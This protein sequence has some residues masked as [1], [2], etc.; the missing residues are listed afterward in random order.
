M[1]TLFYTVG[2]PASGKS[3][4]ARKMVEEANGTLVAIS[5]DELRARP[6]APSGRKRERWVVEQQSAFIREHLAAGTSVIVH[7][8]NFNPVHPARF[9]ALADE[10]G[11][12]LHKLDLTH[13]DVHECIRRDAARADHVGESVI[14]GMWQKYCYTPPVSHPDPALAA[15]VLVDIDGTLARMTGRSPYHWDRVHEDEPVGHVVELVRDLAG[16]GTQ[17]VFLS[18]RD[19]SCRDATQAWIDKHVGVDGLL[20]MRAA[21]DNRADSIVKAELFDAHVH[22]RFRVRFVLDDRNSVVFMWRSKGIP[23]LQVEYGYF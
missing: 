17:I 22:G 20:L 11:A 13:V 3:T 9:A 16:T 18:G 19:G 21:G 14:M 6:D 1:L 10:F 8:T 4:L 12:E 23:V 7:D 15:A 2:L 5:K